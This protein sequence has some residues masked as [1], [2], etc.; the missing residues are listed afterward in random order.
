MDEQIRQENR[1][2]WSPIHEAWESWQHSLTLDINQA[3]TAVVNLPISSNSFDVQGLLVERL[4]RREYRLKVDDF[5]RVH[6]T[7]TNLHRTIRPALR[8][9]GQPTAHIDIVNSQPAFLAIL[10]GQVGNNTT[11]DACLSSP[12]LAVAGSGAVRYGPVPPIPI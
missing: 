6:N 5:G 11:D 12:A 4:H 10:M 9:D 1:R 2:N 3:R 8:I 7:I